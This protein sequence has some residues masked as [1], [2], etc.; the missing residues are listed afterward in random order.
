MNS[1]DRFD[2][3]K[4]PKKEDFYG[5]LNDKRISDKDHDLEIWNE[6]GRKKFGRML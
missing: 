2:E 6:F 1:F 3:T 5:A 4:L